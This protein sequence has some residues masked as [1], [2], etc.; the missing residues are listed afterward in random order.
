MWAVLAFREKRILLGTAFPAY[1][2]G[3]RLL[4][5]PLLT[6]DLARIDGASCEINNLVFAGIFGKTERLNRKE[7]ETRGKNLAAA[8]KES[9][10]SSLRFL[11]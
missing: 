11:C 8:G 3:L 6:I 1:T 10:E 7:G 5:E 4:T 2:F 9:F